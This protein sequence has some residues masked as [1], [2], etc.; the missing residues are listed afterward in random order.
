LGNDLT[1]EIRMRGGHT[2][3]AVVPTDWAL[4]GNFQEVDLKL[5]K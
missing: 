1:I 5:L 4:K 2:M 3:R